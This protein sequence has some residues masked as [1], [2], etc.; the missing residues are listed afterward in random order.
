MAS[1]SNTEVRQ[2]AKTSKKTELEDAFYL[3]WQLMFPDL[4]AP[5]RQ[6]PILNPKTNRHWKLDF[7]WPEDGKIFVE[8]QGGAFIRGGHT[9][10]LGQHA[11]YERQNMLTRMGWRGLYFNTVALKNMAE[12]VE[13]VA[14]TLCNAK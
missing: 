12:V 6:H 13:F 7:A 5:T 11:D 14:E 8:L 9:T 1:L 4:P 10:A 3:H 2:L